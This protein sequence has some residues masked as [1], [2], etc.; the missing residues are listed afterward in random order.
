MA[1]CE[2]PGLAE[3]EGNFKREKLLQLGST[4]RLSERAQQFS[5]FRI[6][7]LDSGNSQKTNTGHPLSF[8]IMEKVMGKE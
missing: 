1:I 6:K 3:F 4:P 7:K 2:R 8:M 5:K